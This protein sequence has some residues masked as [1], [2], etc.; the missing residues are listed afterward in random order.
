MLKAKVLTPFTGLVL[1]PLMACSNGI[2]GQGACARAQ[3]FSSTSEKLKSMED[4]E[5]L[6]AKVNLPRNTPGGF[7][8][9]EYW[10][11]RSSGKPVINFEAALAA[12]TVEKKTRRCTA[13]VSFDSGFAA[14]VARVW[15]ADHCVRPAS[16]IG[17]T[18][19]LYGKGG[20]AAFPVRNDLFELITRA[21]KDSASL[22]PAAREFFLSTFNTHQT[23]SSRAGSQACLALRSSPATNAKYTDPDFA[24][25]Y[26]H[27]CFS[28][29][30]LATFRVT[31]MGSADT[32]NAN[33]RI[34]WDET[35]SSHARLRSYHDLFRD[36]VSSALGEA[37]FLNTFRELMN[38]RRVEA[39]AAFATQ[40]DGGKCD[41]DAAAGAC[42]PETSMKLKTLSNHYFSPSKFN[43]NDL[44]KLAD[45]TASPQ[46]LQSLLINA[47]AQGITSLFASNKNGAKSEADAARNRYRGLSDAVWTLLD[48]G[49]R[50]TALLTSAGKKL[51]AGG[52]K[53]DF[54]T[55]NERFKYTFQ[56]N[57]HSSS[58]Q[59]AIRW[60]WL[61]SHRS[62][63]DAG[64]GVTDEHLV[65]LN[66]H[67][68][69]DS[70]KRVLMLS[71]HK[72]K[73]PYRFE[74]GDSGTAVSMFVF[75]FGSLS[76]V[77]WEETEG[78]PVTLL[79]GAGTYKED[80]A[81]A[82][83]GSAGGGGQSTGD[84]KRPG[85]GERGKVN[86]EVAAGADAGDTRG[87][88]ACL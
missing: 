29:S 73:A 9:V 66:L 3:A 81:V 88:S 11:D 61:S 38:V 36:P 2:Q 74:K 41:L 85:K 50:G 55:A 26:S 68:S 59:S 46:G 48:A 47:A 83:G 78:V 57:M 35:K 28:M 64:K 70:F 51:P 40:V 71:S 53:S 62:I 25:N 63:A 10:A 67:D 69:T 24:A 75:P 1:V 52:K 79:P 22:P 32:F 45:A 87:K 6:R 86:G 49:A 76:T 14:S 15:T 42:A 84:A 39:F 65:Q 56:T 44:A 18:L 30:D 23:S 19:Q 17:M 82:S 31:V 13:T 37:M 4:D 12:G 72:E 16:D 54:D 43:E 34:V 80:G 7:V 20:Y 58:E 5:S 27:A 60:R 8:D 21:R 33:Q 77:D